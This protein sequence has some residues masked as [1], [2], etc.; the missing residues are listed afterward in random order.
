M[1]FPTM[2]RK[3]VART[4]RFERLKLDFNITPCLVCCA[5]IVTSGEIQNMTM[6]ITKKEIV[7]DLCSLM[8]AGLVPSS[9]KACV[10]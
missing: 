9:S 10:F 2:S 6:K 5:L 8:R 7:S 4:A 3:I 1:P